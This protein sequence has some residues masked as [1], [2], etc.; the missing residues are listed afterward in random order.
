MQTRFIIILVLFG[1]I[2]AFAVQNSDPV[3]LDLWFWHVDSPLAFIMLACMA[4]GSLISL[5]L[6]VPGL[7]RRKKQIKNLEIKLKEL[8]DQLSDALKNKSNA[9][10]NGY[11]TIDEGLLL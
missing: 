2:A 10:M 1:L 7:F 5:I 11:E 6:S 8:E 9:Q 3:T 4:G